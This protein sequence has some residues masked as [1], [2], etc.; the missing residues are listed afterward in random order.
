MHVFNSKAGLTWLA[1]ACA[2][3]S[4]IPAADQASRER[5]FRSDVQ[6]LL[7]RYCADCHGGGVAEGDLDLDRFKSARDVLRGRE[8][9][10]KVL[11]KLAVAGRQ[12]VVD[13]SHNFVHRQRESDLR[14]LRVEHGC[15]SNS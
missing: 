6:P 8:Q 2:F 11:Q 4:P 12:R 10:L 5:D 15:G 7:Q 1:C 14:V 13:L 9:W 3:I